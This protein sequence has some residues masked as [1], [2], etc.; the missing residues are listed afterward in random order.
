MTETRPLAAAAAMIA[1]MAI[2][3][4]IDNF[5]I[6]VAETHGLWQFHIARTALAVP[7]IA[8]GAWLGWGTIRPLRAWAVALRSA[9][10][11]IAMMIYFGCLAFLPIAEVAA[12]LF[13]S[14]LWVLV[15]SVLS[16]RERVGP[17][18]TIAALV[19]FAGV[20]MVLRPDTGAF[21]AQSLVP[22]AAGFFYALGVLTT[23]I[24]CAGESTNSLL[25]GN[26]VFLALFAAV[27]LAAVY[28][29]GPD[30]RPG[31][32][33]FL[34]RRWLPLTPA[35]AFW[36]AVQAVGSI[37]GVWL[38]IRSYQWGEASFSASFEYSLLIFVSLWAWVLRGEVLD[39]WAAAGIAL[40]V[41]SGAAIALR[42]R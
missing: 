27:G 31:P 40:I 5:V 26:F 22:L 39:A 3:G 29:I 34:A 24:W 11:G 2:I 19:G 30:A 37:V 8:L 28:A 20:L 7:L 42:G 15:I 13:T 14:P 38:L 17:V 16:G 23:R 33:G 12:G 25:A 1:A 35:F 21:S 10:I 41:V 6:F 9:L 4:L 36:V 32:D 18:R